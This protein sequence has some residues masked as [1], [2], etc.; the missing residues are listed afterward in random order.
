AAPGEVVSATPNA[1]AA[2]AGGRMREAGSV[3]TAAAPA[4]TTASAPPPGPWALP[5]GGGLV[6]ASPLAKRIAKEAG[7]DLRLVR[8]SGPGGRV[9]KRDL[10]GAAARAPEAA[11]AVVEAES[12]PASRIPHPAA[13]IP[14]PA[15]SIPSPEG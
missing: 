5:V 13:L 6:K 9:I 4:T 7:V 10:E 14:H 11:P 2:P 1:A 8:G 3:K 12:H 15:A